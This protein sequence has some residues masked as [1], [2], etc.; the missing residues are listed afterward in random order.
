MHAN[1]AIDE[2][3]LRQPLGLDYVSCSAYRVPVARLTAA[4]AALQT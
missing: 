3:E 4:H 2:L 1:A